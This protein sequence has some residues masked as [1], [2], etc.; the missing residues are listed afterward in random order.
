MNYELVEALPRIIDLDDL[1]E[2]L[3]SSPAQISRCANA[4]NSFYRTYEI[5]KAD[6]GSR[7]INAPLPSLL[8][9]Q[10]EIYGKILS[11]VKPSE[12]AH[13][14]V[15]GRSIISHA[16]QHVKGRDFLLV[17]LKN[18]FPNIKLPVVINIFLQMGYEH[19]I[20]TQL[21]LICTLHKELPQGSPSSPYISNIACLRLDTRLSH[22]AKQFNLSY[23]RYADDLAFSG[24]HIGVSFKDAVASVIDDEGFVLNHEKTLL[25]TNQGKMIITGISISRGRLCLPR[26]T[27]RRLRNDAHRILKNG[28]VAESGGSNIFDPLY[29]DRILGRLSFWTQV[30]PDNE[31]PRKTREAIVSQIK[32]IA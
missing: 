2:L 14:F 31:F 22:L 17:D 29:V 20:A 30:E 5:A 12:Y 11:C 8:Q 1:A 19:S 18:F 23:S 26:A 9:L 4:S 15:P 32:L 13:G 10:K 21:G 25:A 6:G 27:K 7:T 3:Y 16:S 28:I 24:G